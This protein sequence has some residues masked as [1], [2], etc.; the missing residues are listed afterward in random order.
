MCRPLLALPRL[1]MKRPISGKQCL[2]ETYGR[3]SLALRAWRRRGWSR[4]Q[5]RI[6]N[7]IGI[8]LRIH[9]SI[10]DQDRTEA[11]LGCMSAAPLR[12]ASS[13]GLFTICSRLR[14]NTATFAEIILL[15][16]MSNCSGCGR[17]VSAAPLPGP[18]LPSSVDFNET[19]QH[20]YK[21]TRTVLPGKKIRLDWG[22]GGE[23]VRRDR[24]GDEQDKSSEPEPSRRN[25]L[26]PAPLPKKREKSCVPYTRFSRFCNNCQEPKRRTDN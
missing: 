18:Q 9:V 13:R 16:K 14:N 22:G 1:K 12:T 6:N 21:L 8:R 19:L 20:S 5:S 17:G 26:E 25:F 3:H 10:S 2:S 4:G 23:R 11:V 15:R 24:N 7:S